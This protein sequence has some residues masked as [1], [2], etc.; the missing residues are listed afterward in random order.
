MWKRAARTD[1]LPTAQPTG[2]A[3]RRIVPLLQQAGVAIGAL[4]AGGRAGDAAVRGAGGVGGQ[5]MEE[6]VDS[7]AASAAASYRGIARVEL[8]AG[9]PFVA[10]AGR[11][12]AEGPP[13][14][15]LDNPAAGLARVAPGPPP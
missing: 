9:P 7:P 5:D 6:E 2:P 1:Q 11:G 8:S 10:A 4:G 14:L 3:S 12:R 15:S 13:L